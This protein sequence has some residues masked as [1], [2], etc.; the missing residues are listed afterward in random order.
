[1]KT[2]DSI[3][4]DT[5]YKTL[6]DAVAQ[7]PARFK[8]N[9]WEFE[10][11][12]GETLGDARQRFKDQHGFE[13]KTDEEFRQEVAAS[14]EK[15]R[16]EQASAIAS[17]GVMTEQQMRDSRAPWPES[18]DALMAYIKQ[19]VER[20]HDYGTCVYAM[21]LAATAALNYVAGKLGCTGFQASMADMDILR[22]TRGWEIGRILDYATLIYPQCCDEEHFPSY[23]TL[24]NDE[25]LRPELRKRAQ[26][27]LTECQGQGHP[28]VLAHWRRIISDERF[29]VGV[30]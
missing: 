3:P 12:A 23:V 6:C 21:S 18:P 19:V 8:F 4:G 26:A 27:K 17:S 24:L 1:M 25:K 11:R 30:A 16:Q 10:T 15:T 13:V 14:L 2:I 9:D 22:R 28:A 20:P 5:L 7:A 29:T